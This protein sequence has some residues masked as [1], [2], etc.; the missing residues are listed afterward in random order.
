MSVVGDRFRDPQASRVIHGWS[1]RGAHDRF[2]GN[3]VGVAAPAENLDPPPAAPVRG[4]IR[5]NGWQ[6]I[7]HGLY[8][9]S[10]SE[11]AAGP[12]VGATRRGMSGSYPEA[13]GLPGCLDHIRAWATV[14]PPEAAFTHITAAALRGWWLPPLPA[15]LPVFLAVPDGGGRPRR[16]GVHVTRHTAAIEHQFSGGLPVAAPAEILLA[17]A[18]HLGLI[19]L[20]ILGDSALH[21]GDVT[22]SQLNLAAGRRRRG[23][24]A[25]R[26]ALPMMDGRAESP[27]ETL[28]RLLHTTCDI[29]VEP[30]L[31]VMDEYG[32]TIARADL[33]VAGTRRLAEYDGAH[34]RD[35][36]QYERDRARDRR[37]M[38][39]GWTPYS[40]SANTV[41]RQPH[42]IIRDADQALGRESDPRLL[43][44]WY[45]LIQN[46][47][48]TGA[49]MA[50][51][52][53][54]LGL[55]RKSAR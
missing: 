20:V 35:S 43:G 32:Q 39:L 7:S 22:M 49:G 8:V 30:Q 54:R 45:S 47:T 5:R 53:A 28:L 13:A 41:L 34:H 12:P 18:R 55:T 10:F 4:R 2:P 37:L 19:D 15:G 14:L 38:E 33:H 1:H 11:T 48:F 3:S 51:L 40:Y 23:A 50:R 44:S 16:L 31:A 36:R 21:L 6:R 29:E 27:G 42:L 17:A 9:P 52:R 25:L 46:S 24:P 26:S